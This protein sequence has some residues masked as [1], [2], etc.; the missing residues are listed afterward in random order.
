MRATLVLLVL[1]LGSARVATA[2]A[3]DLPVR[4]P[5]MAGAG[6][7]AYRGDLVELRLAPAA[8]RAAAAGTA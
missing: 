5:G 4:V 1:L 8:T 3:L 7:P 6:V 2:S